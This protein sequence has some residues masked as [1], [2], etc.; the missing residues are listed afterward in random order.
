MH[1]E[2]QNGVI[3]ADEAPNLSD[4]EAE[5][6]RVRERW[7]HPAAHHGSAERNAIQQKLSHGRS[8]SVAVEIKRPLRLR[9][10]RA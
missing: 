3:P 2:K 1:E 9:A 6:K 4:I 8:R 5:T 7:G 10:P